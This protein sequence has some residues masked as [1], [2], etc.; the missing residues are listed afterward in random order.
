MTSPTKLD[1]VRYYAAV[2]AGLVVGEVLMTRPAPVP[3]APTPVPTRVAFVAPL[4]LRPGPA[5]IEVTRA[6][7]RSCATSHHV[8]VFLAPVIT[9]LCPPLASESNDEEREESP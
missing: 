6:T 4:E 5:D 9:E 8:D 2:A 1:L 3:A 7:T